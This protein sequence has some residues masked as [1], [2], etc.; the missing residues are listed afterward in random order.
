MSDQ[1][2]ICKHRLKNKET[3]TKGD[4]DDYDCSNCGVYRLAGNF[5][6]NVHNE[7]IEKSPKI[8]PY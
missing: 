5:L 2:P 4:F 6:K 8:L 7:W 1:C 3:V